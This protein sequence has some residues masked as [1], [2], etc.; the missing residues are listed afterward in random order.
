MSSKTA[1]HRDSRSVCYEHHPRMPSV[2]TKYNKAIFLAGSTFSARFKQCFTCFRSTGESCQ[3]A[4]L[5]FPPPRLLGSATMNKTLHLLQPSIKHNQ[6]SSKLLITGKMG[7]SVM[8]TNLSSPKPIW[9][10]F[11]Q[12]QVLLKVSDKLAGVVKM[13]LSVS[14]W[15][16]IADILHG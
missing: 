8:S 14:S 11:Q 10:Y 3:D 16:L 9:L 12:V 4:T 2:F 7:V 5:L 6:M 13:Q 1:Y 15:W